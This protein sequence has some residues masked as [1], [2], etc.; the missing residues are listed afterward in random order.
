MLSRLIITFLCAA[1]IGS[2]SGAFLTFEPDQLIVKDIEASIIFL[3]GLISKPTEEVT[4]HFQN[5]FMSISTC[6][7]V[8][9]PNNWNTPQLLTAIPAPLFVGSSDPPGR[10]PF[11]SELLAKKVTASPLPTELPTI[12]ALQVTR[13]NAPRHACSAG[14][15]LVDLSRILASIRDE[16]T[17]N[18]NGLR[19]TRGT[20]PGE[21]KV[22]FP[23][24]SEVNIRVVNIDGAVFLLVFLAI[25]SGYPSP[26]GL[27]NIPR[28]PS[29]DNKLVGSDGKLYDPE[30]K[31]EVDAF[32]Q[33]WRVNI[34]D[35]LTKPG[36]SE[37]NIPIRPGT[38]CKFPKNPP[39]KP[40]TTTTTTVDLSTTMDF[41]TYVSSFTV[42]LSKSTLSP[43]ITYVLSSTTI[44]TSPSTTSTA[45]P[46]SPDPPTPGGYGTPDP[47]EYGT[48]DPDEH[49][50]PSEDVY[51]RSSSP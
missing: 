38:V 8:F 10:L 25:D 48:P 43:T 44:T 12:D 7:I 29:P 41:S 27:C 2:V 1:T 5:P 23:Y 9:N 45:L 32:I 36:A 15:M 51:V 22:V 20:K 46:I 40:T 31:D 17:P 11:K 24:G 16:V 4:V 33:S 35:V 19:Y 6:V 39:P 26:R 37:L 21:H 13:A 49:V 42:D 30:K 28:P 14:G 50:S 18:V 34:K 47:D 3:V